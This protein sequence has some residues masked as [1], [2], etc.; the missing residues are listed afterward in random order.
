MSRT[1]LV[2]R[3]TNLLLAGF[4]GYNQRF[5]LIT[6]RAA[7]RFENRDW[8]GIRSDVAERIDLYDSVVAEV[9]AELN[10]L[11]GTSFNDRS[12]WHAIRRQ[13]AKALESRRDPEFFKTF[14]SSVTRRV[15]ATIGVD[16]Q[17]EFLAPEVEPSREGASRLRRRVFDLSGTLEACCKDILEAYEFRVPYRDTEASA[18]LLAAEV[19][20]FAEAIGERRRIESIE[21]LQPVFFQSLRAYLVGKLVGRDWFQPLVIALTNTE[22]GVAVDAVL[23][24]EDDVS[25]LFSFT[26]SYILAD[27]PVVSP[28]VSYLRELM[29]G[30]AIDEI[31]TV[32]GR[33]KQGKTER[34]GSFFRHL[35]AS[36]DQFEFAAGSKGMVM[37]VFTLPSFPVVFKVIRNRFP[38]P[39]DITREGVKEKYRLVFTRDRA[40]RLVDAQEFRRLQLPTSR[41]TA[42]VLEELVS[43]CS[44]TCRVEGDQLIVEHCYIERRLTPLNLFLRQAEDDKAA[45][46]IADYG[47]AIRDLART[48]IFP[49]D[50]LLKNFG[51]TRH[52]R[53]I[54]YDYDELCLVTDCRFR[55]LPEPSDA[56]D[57]M[58]AGEWF[59]VAP[60]DIFPEQFAPFLGLTGD[61]G[62]VFRRL[63]QELLTGSYWRR[64]KRRLAAGEIFDVIP[65]RNRAWS[66]SVHG[67]V[68]TSS[69]ESSP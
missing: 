66:A 5:G 18:A 53:V 15:F 58:R 65:Y 35:A 27:F 11:Q 30:K 55:D 50:L 64:L 39:K 61:L 43:D 56:D 67:Y 2:E 36:E 52:G 19:S 8:A 57:E 41:F 16:S 6:R 40:G 46:A 29:P 12:L 21:L 38:Y 32:L 9:V 44:M 4:Q 62:A 13:Y 49:G 33:A 26:R 20:G 37:A 24:S 42:S 22:K 54:F 48:N 25:M 3:S 60:N 69:G 45:D 14:F 59:Y 17:V 23:L 1:I 10:V 7:R 63:H 34:F 51:V 68:G 28:L 47:Q 31:Y